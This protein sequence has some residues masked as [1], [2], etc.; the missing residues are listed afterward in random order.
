MDKAVANAVADAFGINQAKWCAFTQYD[1]NKNRQECIDT[2]VNKLGFPIFVKPA[3]A[4]SS[5][6]ITKAHDVPELIEAMNVAFNED[7]KA[8]LQDYYI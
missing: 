8:V 5:V 6:G 3:N 1:F 7:K 4:G 2:A